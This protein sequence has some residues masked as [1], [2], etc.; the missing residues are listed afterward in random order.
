MG[1]HVIGIIIEAGA[2]QFGAAEIVGT[3]ELCENADRSYEA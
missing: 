2:Q 3:P 1:V